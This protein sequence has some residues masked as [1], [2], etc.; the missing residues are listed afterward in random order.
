M[1]IAYKILMCLSL[2]QLGGCF[3]KVDY[4][5]DP[6]KF[7]LSS[8]GQDNGVVLMS[9]GAAESCL[10]ASTLLNV[11][12]STDPWNQIPIATLPVDNSIFKSQFS[13]HHG[14]LYVFEIP[15]GDYN[16]IP[17][18]LDTVPIKMPKAPFSID[19]G[20]VLYLGEYRM[21]RSCSR[22]ISGEFQNRYVRD[23]EILKLKNPSLAET[24]VT[25]RLPQFS[26]YILGGEKNDQ[27]E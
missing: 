5:K 8:L 12:K 9:V 25:V 6:S 3:L 22:V 27:A 2:L 13:D 24:V 10:I 17:W 11:L 15:A 18:Q 21:L 14:G 19:A 23:L 20:E 26:G 7:N 1:S 4:H 16:I